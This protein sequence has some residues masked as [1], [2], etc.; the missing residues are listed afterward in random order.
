MDSENPFFTFLGAVFDQWMTLLGGGALIVII[1]L[2]ERRFGRQLHWKLYQYLVAALLFYACYLAWRIEH[3][4][5]PVQAPSSL[6]TRKM[7]DEFALRVKAADQNLVQRLNSSNVSMA[8]TCDSVAIQFTED[9]LQ[10]FY[11]SGFYIQRSV[12]CNSDLDNDIKG[13]VI[14]VSDQKNPPAEAKQLL[15]ILRDSE[16]PVSPEL[17]SVPQLNEPRILFWLVHFGK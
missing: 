3:D 1:G 11:S 7:R 5:Q 14:A 12:F 2:I 15:K 17:I 8:F 16:I 4:K 13:L 10:I 6:L 9:L